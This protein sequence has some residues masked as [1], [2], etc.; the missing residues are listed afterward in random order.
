MV[1]QVDSIGELIQR[2]KFVRGGHIRKNGKEIIA[3]ELV[4]RKEK[5]RPLKIYDGMGALAFV[6]NASNRKAKK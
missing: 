3:T 4:L 2:A 1:N 6:L 5:T